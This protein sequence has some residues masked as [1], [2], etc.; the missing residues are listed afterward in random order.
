MVD[1]LERLGERQTVPLFTYGTL[2]VGGHRHD[3][4]KGIVVSSH[5]GKVEGYDLFAS[6]HVDYPAM[7]KSR[8]SNHVVH[9]D[10]YW[11]KVGKSFLE[12]VQM[13]LNVGYHMNLVE[14]AVP[15]LAEP[16][17]ALSFTF[18]RAPRHDWNRILSGDWLV[19]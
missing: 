8:Y 13:E 18:P 7:A 17:L 16:V 9:G 19:G 4:V 1:I 10:L 15:Q 12:L 6:E 5:Q 3:W 2:R 14:V 11:L